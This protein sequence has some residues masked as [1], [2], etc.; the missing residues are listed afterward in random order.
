[1]E[2][3]Q[4]CLS[5]E[6]IDVEETP[7]VL[8]IASVEALKIARP[9][10]ERAIVEELCNGYGYLAY[11]CEMDVEFCFWDMFRRRVVLLA[12]ECEE[13][14]AEIPREERFKLDFYDPSVNR[15]FLTKEA[16][17]LLKEIRFRIT[18]GRAQRDLTRA[19]RKATKAAAKLRA[20]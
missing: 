14:Q 1:M 11:I 18:T 2:N 16:I 5:D 7:D 20:A 12:R 15:W 8:H 10:I 19:E 6:R 4:I 3:S 17:D 9:I 13:K